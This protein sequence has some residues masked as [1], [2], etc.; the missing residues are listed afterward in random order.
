MNNLII[1]IQTE[2]MKLR[3]SWIVTTTFGLFIFIPAMMG[4]LMFIAQ[5]PHMAEKLGL[6]GAK[7]KFFSE[8]SW[9]GYFEIIN[10]VVAVMGI[11]AFGFVTSWVFGR[12]YI[13][14]TLTDLLSLPVSRSSIISAKF[15]IATIWCIALSIVM[16]LSALVF[17]RIINIPGWSYE[18]F[19][20]FSQNFFITVLLTI[21]LNT[22]IGY[23]C[24][25]SRGII[26]PIGFVLFMVVMAQLIA[27]V[28][29]GPYFPW[30]IPGVFSV[31]DS[32]SGFHLVPVSYIILLLTSLAGIG[33]TYNYW[34]NAD[35]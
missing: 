4:L 16:Y 32:E 19:I 14:N 10:Q 17:G 33:A 29:W 31:S 9:L 21:M 35:Q 5:N 18:V 11:I 6:I 12:E 25:K 34:N 3:R 28:G 2:I 23:V 8:N 7:A 22:V 24:G 15:V 30:A 26:A 13:E 1:A 20:G 27:M